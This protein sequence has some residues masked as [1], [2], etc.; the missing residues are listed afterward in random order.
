MTCMFCRRY[1]A[2]KA[3]YHV[4]SPVENWEIKAA[5]ALHMLRDALNE[6]QVKAGAMHIEAVQRDFIGARPT[7]GALRLSIEERTERVIE[8]S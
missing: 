8:A 7:I 2:E 4:E 5:T 1:G 6:G 3:E